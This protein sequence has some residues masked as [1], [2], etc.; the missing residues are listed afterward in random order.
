MSTSTTGALSSGVQQLYNDGLLPSS[1][2]AS[3]LNNASASQLNK[4]VGSTLALQQVNALF[5]TG[6]TSS[7]SASLSS[8]ATNALLQEI[9]PSTTTT[10][11]ID[12]L[13]AAVD[14]ALTSSINAAVSKFEPS[15]T[16]TTGS[17]VN[18]VG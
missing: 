12:P 15:S 10:S 8:T 7:D 11:T 9:N 3:T 18:V 14:N 16:S 4:I 1:L 17:T 13:T 6:T 2:N 5:G